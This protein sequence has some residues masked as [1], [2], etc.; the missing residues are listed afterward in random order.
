[1][2]ATV[3]QSSFILNGSTS[4][5]EVVDIRLTDWQNGIGRVDIQG[6]NPILCNGICPKNISILDKA[7]DPSLCSPIGHILMC[8][9]KELKH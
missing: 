9:S 1:M 4:R 6:A 3:S 2:S 5:P 8:I 7:G